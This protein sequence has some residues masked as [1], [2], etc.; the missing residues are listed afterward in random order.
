MAKIGYPSGKASMLLICVVGLAAI[1][2]VLATT[3]DY[4]DP[5]RIPTCYL[6]ALDRIA[7]TV[8]LECDDESIFPRLT[9]RSNRGEILLRGRVNDLLRSPEGQRIHHHK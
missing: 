8:T 5:L 6:T 3:V 4:E 2:C 1:T 7:I 9:C